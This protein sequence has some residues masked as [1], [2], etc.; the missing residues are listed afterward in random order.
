MGQSRIADVRMPATGSTCIAFRFRS[1]LGLLSG[2]R[3]FDAMNTFDGD[4]KRGL[5]LIE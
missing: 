2:D 5:L 3:L 1:G 4:T